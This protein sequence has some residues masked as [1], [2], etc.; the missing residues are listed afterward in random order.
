MLTNISWMN[1][2]VTIGCLLTA[3][4]LLLGIY[5]AKDLKPLLLKNSGKFPGVNN[6]RNSMGDKS[7]DP[8]ELAQALRNEILET[9]QLAAHWHNP[10]E[11]IIMALQIQL[12]GYPQLK[13]TA[14]EVAISH[15]IMVTSLHQCSI[16]FSDEELQVLWKG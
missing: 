7:E 8:F 10:K 13:A 15:Y 1:F 9:F 11:E 4:Y 5:Y 12:R 16:S 6:K 3:W 2:V 14:F